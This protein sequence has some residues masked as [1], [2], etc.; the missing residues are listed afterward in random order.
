MQVHAN[1]DNNNTVLAMRLDPNNI[2]DRV[3][4]FILG[5]RYV[6]TQLEGTNRT[7]RR[8]K[9]VTPPK[10]NECGLQSFMSWFTT[11]INEHTVQGNKSHAECYNSV[12]ELLHDINFLLHTN[13]NKWGMLQQDIDLIFSQVRILADMF[14]TRTIDNKEREG[15]IPTIRSEERNVIHHTPQN[16]GLSE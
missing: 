8:K 10:M 1:L 15:M 12:A 4:D 16:G 6:E 11:A 13:K 3:Q 9:Q 5:Y 7:I 2:L 14:F